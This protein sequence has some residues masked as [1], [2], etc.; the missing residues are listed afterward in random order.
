MKHCIFQVVFLL[1]TYP[2][3]CVISQTSFIIFL[4]FK[5][6]LLFQAF[7]NC[8]HLQEDSTRFTLIMVNIKSKI[9]FLY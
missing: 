3:I 7:S 1:I 4:L 8:F 2:Q 5:T 9:Y 6:F